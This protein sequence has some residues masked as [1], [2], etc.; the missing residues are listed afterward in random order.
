MV[1]EADYFASQLDLFA[2]CDALPVGDIPVSS[3]GRT[4]P[5]PF[6]ATEGLIFEPCLKKS[7]RPK[8]QCLKMEN[9]QTQGWQNC[10]DVKLRGASSTLNIGES[11]NV[12]VESSLSQILQ[13]ECDV[14][15]KYYLS[16]KACR[17]ILRRARERGKE[18]P[19]ELRAA[20]ERQARIYQYVQEH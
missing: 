6:P 19:E 2:I 12:A 10:Q 5:E 3:S 13:P 20:L 18:L 7:Q 4:S 17:G 16:P 1:Q 8:F 11:P 15:G 14:P 9:G